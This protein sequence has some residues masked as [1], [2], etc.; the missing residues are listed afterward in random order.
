MVRLPES[1]F[2]SALPYVSQNALHTLGYVVTE[3]RF[4]LELGEDIGLLNGNARQFSS[5]MKK[6]Q[7]GFT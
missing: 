1:P 7:D 6:R 5:M 4:G 3:H 2:S